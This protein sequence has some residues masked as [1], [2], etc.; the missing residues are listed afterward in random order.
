M[1]YIV[2]HVGSRAS[3]G[4]NVAPVVKNRCHVFLLQLIGVSMAIRFMKDIFI[5]EVSLVDEPANLK[6][7]AIIK[8][9]LGIKDMDELKKLVEEF[10]GMTLDAT[11]VEKAKEMD[12]DVAA[13][14]VE[15]LTLLK[16]YSDD[17]P[18]AVVSAIGALS[19][20]AAFGVI[21]KVDDVKKDKDTKDTSKD[22]DVVALIEDAVAKATKDL[23]KDDVKKDDR[24]D[25]L[26][27]K[28]IALETQVAE[29]VSK[30]TAGKDD[31]EEVTEEYLAEKIA[32]RVAALS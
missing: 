26:I 3:C 30:A 12:K 16:K 18:A 21:T 20:R 13:G 24:V 29:L 9:M 17:F 10:T 8:S 5:S 2:K 4:N 15:T 7:F 32:E 1:C 25:E 22:V 14:L 11:V 19:A 6:R 28:F 31:D 23:V 27:T